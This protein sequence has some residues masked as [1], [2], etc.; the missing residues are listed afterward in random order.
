MDLSIKTK[1]GTWLIL[2]MHHTVQMMVTREVQPNVTYKRI[3]ENIPPKKTQIPPIIAGN[4]GKSATHR[5][6]LGA[7][8]SNWSVIE[9]SS[10]FDILKVNRN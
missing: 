6:E 5:G 2:R 9:S 4:N 7:A 8:L 1:F 3:L 10:S